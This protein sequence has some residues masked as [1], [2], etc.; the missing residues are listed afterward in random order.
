M[1]VEEAKTTRFPS[2]LMI[3][4]PAPLSETA[5]AGPSA[6]E[7]SVVVWLLMSRT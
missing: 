1:V 7:T 2:A 3:G 4:V 6:R 5:P